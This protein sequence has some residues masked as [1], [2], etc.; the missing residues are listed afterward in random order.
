MGSLETKKPHF[1]G[2]LFLS[3]KALSAKLFFWKSDCV[4]AI[5]IRIVHKNLRRIS[6]YHSDSTSEF[7]CIWSNSSQYLIK[8]C[9]LPYDSF[10]DQKD[11]NLSKNEVLFIEGNSNYLILR[12]LHILSTIFPFLPEMMKILLIKLFEY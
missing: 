5:L 1:K 10:Q 7:L 11:L 8:F 9:E 3:V 4:L 12:L 6:D 2:F